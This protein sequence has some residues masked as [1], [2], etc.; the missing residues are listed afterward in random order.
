MSNQVMGYAL[1]NLTVQARDITES[2]SEVRR[3]GAGARVGVVPCAARA[4]RGGMGCLAV[5]SKPVRSAA[6]ATGW[7]CQDESGKKRESNRNFD[8]VSIMTPSPA[9]FSRDAASLA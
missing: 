9:S 8:F 6:L 5:L 1:G 3:R 4:A 2:I 7:R